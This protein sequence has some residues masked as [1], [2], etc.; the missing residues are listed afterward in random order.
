MYLDFAIW[1]N[2][3]IDK[4]QGTQRIFVYLGLYIGIPLLLIG[5]VCISNRLDNKNK[6]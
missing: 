6:I 3:T 5:L 1:L 2:Q 4:L